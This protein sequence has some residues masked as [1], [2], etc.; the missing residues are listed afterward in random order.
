MNTYKTLQKSASAELTEKRSRFIA[1][2]K[3]VEAEESA[4]EFIKEIKN[5]NW[6]ARHN[7]YAYMIKDKNITRYSD[8]GE[9]HGTAGIP[10][11]NV[12][13]G[14]EL[15]DAVIVVTRY[16]GGI[17]LGTG[18]LARAYSRAAQMGINAAKIEEMSICCVCELTCTYDQYGKILN[19]I[20]ELGGYTGDIDFKDAITVKFYVLESL[21]NAVKKKISEITSGHIQVKLMKK[22]FKNIKSLSG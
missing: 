17:L 3:P 7:V 14:M 20:S 12:L 6:D 19:I 4:L 13:K 9:P 15:T 11:L 21:F 10:V 18:G 5:K 16:F 1:Y 8:D 2:A 22:E